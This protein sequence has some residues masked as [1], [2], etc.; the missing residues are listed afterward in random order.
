MGICPGHAEIA[1]AFGITTIVAVTRECTKE[2]CAAA[3]ATAAPV[4]EG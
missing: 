3:A 2:V 4:T 1:G